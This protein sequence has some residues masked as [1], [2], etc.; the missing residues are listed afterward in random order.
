MYAIIK[1]DLVNRFVNCNAQLQ[2]IHDIRTSNLFQATIIWY[3][4][5]IKYN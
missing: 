5:K 3:M 4:Y 2:K 1:Y